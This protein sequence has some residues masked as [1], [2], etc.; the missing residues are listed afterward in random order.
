MAATCGS[1]TR[2]TSKKSFASMQ[3]PSW[4]KMPLDTWHLKA[5]FGTWPV[6]KHT[7]MA[8]GEHDKAFKRV[9]T[10][11]PL[12]HQSSNLQSLLWR[13]TVYRI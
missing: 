8:V 4:R 12:F 11:G 3:K 2:G 13:N 6:E 7:N 9:A 5:E 10:L 1:P